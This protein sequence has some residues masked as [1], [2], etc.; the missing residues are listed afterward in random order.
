[1]F[2]NKLKGRGFLSSFRSS[3]AANRSQ[4]FYFPTLNII[5]TAIPKTGSTSLKKYLFSL[6]EEASGDIEAASAIRGGYG[7]DIHSHEANRK[8]LFSS[9]SLSR[10]KEELALK[11][12]V[13]RNPVDRTISAWLNKFLFVPHRSRE[14]LKYLGADF[15]PTSFQGGAVEMRRYLEKF[16]NR[17]DNDPRF[18]H[19]D[20][21]W[22]PQSSLI[23][24]RDAFDVVIETDKLRTLPEILFNHHDFLISAPHFRDVLRDRRIGKENSSNPGFIDALSSPGLEDQIR[25][26]YRVDFELFDAL[27]ISQTERILRAELLNFDVETELGKL[28]NEI[29]E[30]RV[31]FLTENLLHLRES[32]TWKLTAP[33]RSL[34]KFRL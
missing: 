15:V 32:K 10:T 22:T 33:I 8:F 11:L 13:V 14:F 34:S 1:V 29:L 2:T 26:I 9:R 17:L 23:D 25:S 12:L 27:G 30:R 19:G 20:P 6:E 24:R 7:D 18:L 31:A 16:V 4:K 3:R 21:H 5:F 28:A